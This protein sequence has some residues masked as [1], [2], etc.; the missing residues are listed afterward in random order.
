M[1]LIVLLFI[2]LVLFSNPGISQ[3]VINKSEIL[4]KSNEC[5]KSL[6]REDCKMLIL[7]LEQKQIIEFERN[8]FKCQSSILGLQTEIVQAHFSKMTK[9]SNLGI[10]IPYVIKNC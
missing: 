7:Y 10:M 2:N 4:K 9:K 1:K 5:F 3:S 6:L 8:R